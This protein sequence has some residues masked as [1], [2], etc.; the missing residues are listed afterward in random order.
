MYE[1]FTDAINNRVMQSNFLLVTTHSALHNPDLI[2]AHCGMYAA[3]SRA[4]VDRRTD[5]TTIEVSIECETER[6]DDADEATDHTI[7]GRWKELLDR[8]STS[9]SL[10]FRYQFV[11]HHVSILLLGDYVRLALSDRAGIICS[12]QVNYKTHPAKLGLVLWRLAHA[13][14]EARGHD[15]SAARILRG[16]PETKTLPADDHTRELFAETL[17]EDYPWYRLTVYCKDGMKDFLVTKPNFIAPGLVGRGTH[18]YVAHNVGDPKRPF[19]YLKDCWRVIHGRSEQ[20][21]EI[22]AYLNSKGVRYIPTL[23]CHGD[24]PGQETVTQTVWQRVNTSS[25]D[26][27][28]VKNWKHQHYRLVV[29]EVGKPISEFSNGRQLVK[30]CIFAHKEAY[31]KAMVIHRDISV[32]NLLMIPVG[33]TTKGDTI[34]RFL[35]TGS[36][37]GLSKRTGDCDIALRHPDSRMGTWQYM[38]VNA[39]NDPLR[40]IDVADDLE[41]FLHVLIWC[42]IRYLP[43]NCTD[44]GHFMHYF[45]DHGETNEHGE[46]TCSLLKRLAISAGRVLTNTQKRVVFLREPLP[47]LFDATIAAPPS[48]SSSASVA[49][50]TLRSPP[51]TPLVNPPESP[52]LLSHIPE[53]AQHPIQAIVSTLLQQF[54]WYYTLLTS[55]PK[56]AELAMVADDSEGQFRLNASVRFD[57]D[58]DADMD[59]SYGTTFAHGS[60]PAHERDKMTKAVDNHR[61]FGELL[62]NFLRDKTLEWPEKDR[63]ADQLD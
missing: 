23:V 58:M 10:V 37:W 39:L 17:D 52:V 46:Y 5:W 31:D 42:A 47:T 63:L 51:S 6:A 1:A 38:S 40:E 8:N 60:I 44:V 48:S 49:T 25:E 15:P 33:K 59:K 61:V 11:T 35:L 45:F 26:E 20:E 57:T 43:H 9:S 7:S 32:G 22:L 30:E 18:G 50:P 16:T 55:T 34:Y 21:D 4:I 36:G 28:R 2:K 12:T 24:V 27:C 29:H 14:P 19:V 3:G 41:S 53:E 13:T 54:M 62:T 56:H